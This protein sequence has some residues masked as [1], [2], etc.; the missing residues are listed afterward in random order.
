MIGETVGPY[1]EA[2]HERGIT[3]ARGQATG[4]LPQCRI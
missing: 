3:G 2:A 1:L 4:S